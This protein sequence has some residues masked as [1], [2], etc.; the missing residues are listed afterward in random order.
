MQSFLYRLKTVEKI[1]YTL[2]IILAA[3]M[4]KSRELYK[5]IVLDRGL[6]TVPIFVGAILILRWIF[7]FYEQKYHSS[8]KRLKELKNNETDWKRSLISKMDPVIVETLREIVSS[9][10]K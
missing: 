1:V 8:K 7:D 10:M 9:D 3:C 6:I 2:T 4:Y 5:Y